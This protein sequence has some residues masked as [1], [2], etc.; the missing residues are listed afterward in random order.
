MGAQKHTVFVTGSTGYLGRPLVANLVKRGH[1]VR[2]LI[3][4]GSESKL[5]SGCQAVAGDALRG[6]SYAGQIPPADTLVQLV[7]VAH[8]S[9]SKGAQFRSV[10]L[11]SAHDAVRAAKNAGVQHFVYVSVA[12]PAPMMKAYIQVRS[13]CEQTIRES[14]LNATILRP[15]YVLGPG[16]RWP[17]ALIPIYRLMEAIPATRQSALRLGLVTHQQMVRALL[18][19]VENP[20]QGIRIVEVPQI[21]NAGLQLETQLAPA[22]LPS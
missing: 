12:H 10:D 11:V 2:A 9:P 21:R 5:P 6:E 20:C 1:D 22:D 8:P 19:A 16:H 7:G 4:R 13:E 18:S 14:G 3:R 17:Y 15:W